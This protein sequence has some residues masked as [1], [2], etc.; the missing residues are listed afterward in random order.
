MISY[1]N[2]HKWSLINAD[3]RGYILSKYNLIFK[4]TTTIA[5]I[6][7]LKI[8]NNYIIFLLIESIIFIVQNTYNGS[9]VNKLYPYV[10]TK[11][12]IK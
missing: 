10:K 8:T 2:A 6:V 11:Q 3:Q 9:V 5:Q 1:F 12:N 4:V 7:I